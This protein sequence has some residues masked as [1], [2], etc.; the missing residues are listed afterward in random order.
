LK[1]VSTST[2]P[3]GGSAN[4]SFTLIA[5]ALRSADLIAKGIQPTST[6]LRRTDPLISRIATGPY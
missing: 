6:I 4:P 1:V 2:F 5:L 3:T